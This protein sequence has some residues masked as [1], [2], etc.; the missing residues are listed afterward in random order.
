MVVA[1]LQELIRRLRDPDE[2]ERAFAAEDIGYDLVYEAV[3]FMVE[4]LEVE[5]SRFVREAIVGSL[6]L[7]PG[8]AVVNAVVPLLRSQDAFVRNAG[9]DLLAH[10]GPDSL[11]ALAVMLHDAD[12][13]VRKM[14]LDALFLLE[15]EGAVPV[16]MEALEDPDLNVVITAVEYLGRL[17]ATAAAP[18]V[19]R[20]LATHTNLLLRCACL[21]ALAVIGDMESKELVASLYPSFTA[22]SPLEQ[23]SLTKFL[24]RCG[25]CL[26]LPLL[27]S[28]I[29]ERG[30]AMAKEVIN[31]LQGIFRRSPAEVLPPDLLAA[32]SAYIDSPLNDI[33]KYELLV[34]VGEFR[35]P[36]ILDLLSTHA[37]SRSRLVALGAVEGLG[38]YGNRA[39]LPLL[40]E[41]QAEAVDEDLADAIARSLE[42]LGE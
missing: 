6:R 1:Q 18:A 13:D 37:R 2:D 11:P 35:N 34:F 8:P 20:V 10:Q 38:L 7:M 15:M 17:E 33:N 25:N 5:P 27:I 26:H 23:Y 14:A 4:R 9:I 16:I 22:A 24:A 21:E 42:Q 29:E 39:A 3:P 28:L 32:L 36:E 40:R 30:T 19:N 41:L 12:K 31:A